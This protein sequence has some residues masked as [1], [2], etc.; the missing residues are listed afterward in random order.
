M[1]FFRGSLVLMLVFGVILILAGCQTE[2][3]K[4]ALDALPEGE[5]TRGE[6]L[7]L[8]GVNEAA[9]CATCH[10][11]DEVNLVGPGLGGIGQRASERVGG[12]TAQEYLYNSILRPA[13]Y[14][15]R[16]FSNVM[17]QDLEQKLSAQDIAD[18]I[19]YL[20]TL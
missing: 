13:R 9:A 12:Q 16:G 8:K 4:S 7:F 6:A 20:L 10:R 2:E 17:P 5:V 14:L 15:V 19:A 18:L 1:T 11:T 3:P